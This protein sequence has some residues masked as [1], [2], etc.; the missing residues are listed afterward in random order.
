MDRENTG[1]LFTDPTEAIEVRKTSDLFVDDTA[2]GVSENQINDGRSALDHL[3][4]DEQRHAFL[5]F[6]TGHLLA[7]Y[8]CLDYFYHFIL[9]GTKLFR[10][11]SN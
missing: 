9:K 3:Q 11:T 2:T 8:K 6:S 7:L 4:E 5:L 1:M 10:T